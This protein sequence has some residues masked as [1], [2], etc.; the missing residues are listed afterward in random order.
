[1]GRGGAPKGMKVSVIVF[2]GRG[3]VEAETAL[4]LLKPVGSLVRNALQSQ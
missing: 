4:D 3:T 2:D 1:M